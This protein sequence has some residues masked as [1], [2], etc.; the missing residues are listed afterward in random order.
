MIPPSHAIYWKCL[1]QIGWSNR[2]ELGKR[3]LVQLAEQAN[4]RQPTMSGEMPRVRVWD[5]SGFTGAAAEDIPS[6]AAPIQWHVD[7]VH[8]SRQLGDR[9][10]SRVMG[11]EQS[12]TDFG[13]VLTLENIDSHLSAWKLDIARY[14]SRVDRQQ[15]ASSTATNRFK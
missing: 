9:M 11:V 15:I 3:T 8:F 4:Q 2:V 12:M 5:F 10:I 6:E 1:D 13:T 7:P 14:S